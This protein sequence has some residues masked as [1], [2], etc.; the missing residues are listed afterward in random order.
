MATLTELANKYG[1]D[2]GTVIGR[3]HKYTY[4]YDLIFDKYV[5]KELV[6]LE[7]GLAVGDRSLTGPSS[8]QSRPL[9]CRCG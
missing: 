7:L 3:A 2:K 1:S 4:L 5:D 6:F 8:G 9:R